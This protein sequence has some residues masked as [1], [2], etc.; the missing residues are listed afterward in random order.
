MGRP[1]LHNAPNAAIQSSKSSSP[2]V[3]ASNSTN[4]SKDVEANPGGPMATIQDDD[5]RLLARIGYKQ[6]RGVLFFLSRRPHTPNLQEFLY[7]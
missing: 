7:S 1:E 2:V 4:V 5:E 3:V 6:V